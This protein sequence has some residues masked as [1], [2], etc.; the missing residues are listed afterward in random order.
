MC[1]LVL[2]HEILYLHFSGLGF[3]P[4]VGGVQSNVVPPELT[5]VF[6]VRL[7]VTQDHA[8]F[9]A[10]LNSWCQEAGEG[11]HL[12]F[13]QKNLKNAITPLDDSNPYWSTFKAACDTLQLKVTPAIFPGGTDSRYVRLVGIPALG[14]SPMNNTP[15]LLHDHDEFLNE[16]VFLEGIKIYQSLIPAV[17]NVPGK[18]HNLIT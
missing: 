5:V 10:L 4:I 1:V 15:V 16:K 14:F 9:E 6:D 17:A 8:E 3:C 11:T 2:K 7:A 18:A 13:E 12:H